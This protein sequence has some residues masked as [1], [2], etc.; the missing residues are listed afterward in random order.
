MAESLNISENNKFVSENENNDDKR[1]ELSE[2]FAAPDAIIT[3]EALVTKDDLFFAEQELPPA[4]NADEANIENTSSQSN[5]PSQETDSKLS[6]K[7]DL[8]EEEQLQSPLN[9]K[10]MLPKVAE[11]MLPSRA[12]RSRKFRAT[13]KASQRRKN[14]QLRAFESPFAPS[15]RVKR[16]APQAPHRA[17]KIDPHLEASRSRK[18]PPKMPKLIRPIESIDD[19][20]EQMSSS[21]KRRPLSPQMPPLMP[22]GPIGYDKLSSDGVLKGAVAVKAGQV[23]DQ[24]P[25]GESTPRLS[26]EQQLETPSGKGANDENF[27][28][29]S[30]LLPAHLRPHIAKYYAFARAGDD[31]SDNGNL[32]PDEKIARLDA[33]DSALKGELGYGPDQTPI[34]EKSHRL[35]ESMNALGI[36]TKHGSDLLIAF[37]RDATKLRYENWAELIDYCE[38]SANPVGRYLLDLHGE[39]P[40]DYPYSDALCTALQIL[41]HMQDC[42]EDLADL[43]RCYIPQDWMAQE[44][45]QTSDLTHGELTPAMRAVLDRMLDE[46]EELMRTARVLPKV[47]KNRRL[48]MESATIVNLASRLLK[49]LRQKD[50]LATRIS[51]NKWDFAMA[52]I[53]GIATGLTK[54]SPY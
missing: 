32:S 3:P 49:K 28:V 4:A 1:E 46:T 26:P 34:Y 54:S 15:R 7:S 8:S 19:Q 45:T 18:R 30:F 41:N 38:Y 23:I 36:T 5:E 6:M 29:G 47:V 21:S 50:P 48:A 22:K 20:F 14:N 39:D 13:N 40:E 44:G 53:S 42:G 27:P 2:M 31:I 37:K 9:A 51:L 43:D 10:Q 17:P 24:A 12:P 16:K 52:G 35:R 25:N 33:F 11:N